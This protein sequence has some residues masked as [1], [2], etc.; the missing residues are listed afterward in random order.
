M[1]VSEHILNM[2]QVTPSFLFC[3]Y[4]MDDGD[5]DPTQKLDI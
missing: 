5:K 2:L 3:T 4:S 1:H